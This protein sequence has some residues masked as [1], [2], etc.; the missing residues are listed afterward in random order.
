MNK[1]APIPKFIMLGVFAVAFTS[2]FIPL[3]AGISAYLVGFGFL[4]LAVHVAEYFF[5]KDRLAAKAPGENHFLPVLLFG[6][7]YIKP[8]LRD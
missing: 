6:V 4:V 3:M 5:Y 7:L 1:V 8:V 2:P